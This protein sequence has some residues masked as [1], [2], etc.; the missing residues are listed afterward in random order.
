M[1]TRDPHGLAEFWA[2]VLG[3]EI[4]ADEPT[5]VTVR[6]D[7]GRR[8]SF[9]LSPEHEAPK[10]PD[11]H[12]SQQFHLDLEVDDVDEAERQVLALGATRV[13]D[14]QEDNTFRVFR[15]PAGHTFC[16]VYDVTP[17]G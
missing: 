15:D 4:V 10:F 17:A 5:W 11:T 8:L 16:L 13:R 7:R 14:A 6:D 9:Q 3:G 1:D 2:K 12:G